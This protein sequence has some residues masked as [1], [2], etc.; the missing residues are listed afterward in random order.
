[1][2]FRPAFRSKIFALFV[3]AAM[4]LFAAVARADI[5]PASDVLLQQHVFLPYQPKVCSQLQEPRPAVR[6]RGRQEPFLD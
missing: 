1:M 4:S 5:D 6:A 2:R 3:A